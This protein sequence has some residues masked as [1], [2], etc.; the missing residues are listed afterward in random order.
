VF[1]L[2]GS[3]EPLAPS[4]GTP[5]VQPG[6]F[7]LSRACS[8]EARWVGTTAR[9]LIHV[10]RGVSYGD[11]DTGPTVPTLAIPTATQRRAFELLNAVIPLTLK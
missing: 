4:P 7:G 3:V 10:L 2:D 1:N 8:R 5:P 6:T 9:R 11:H